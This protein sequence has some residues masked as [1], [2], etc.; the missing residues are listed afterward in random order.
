MAP[1]GVDIR[2]AW[3]YYYCV[4]GRYISD[5]NGMLHEHTEIRSTY[6]SIVGSDESGAPALRPP[7]GEAIHAV[8]SLLVVLLFRHN[9]IYAG[10]SL[11]MVLLLFFCRKNDPI[12]IS[13]T[14]KFF[15][16]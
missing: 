10:C 2:N 16:S 14:S 11:L 15:L 12:Q 4:N 13:S 5:R 7:R 3:Y 9:A 6:V 1:L 8:L